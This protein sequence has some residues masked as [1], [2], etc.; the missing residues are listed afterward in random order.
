[1]PWDVARRARI[2]AVA[3]ASLEITPYPHCHTWGLPEKWNKATGGGALGGWRRPLPPTAFVLRAGIQNSSRS[4]LQ[5]LHTQPRFWLC[6]PV[7]CRMPALQLRKMSQRSPP[8]HHSSGVGWLERSWSLAT[9]T[10][11]DILVQFKMV[12]G[13]DQFRGQSYVQEV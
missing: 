8:P 2:P 1:M 7:A 5:P 4:L 12:G 13:H 11:P 3:V 10:H 9:L 6:F